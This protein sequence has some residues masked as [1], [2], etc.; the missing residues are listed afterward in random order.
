MD[1]TVKKLW[2]HALICIF[3][4]T[5]IFVSSTLYSRWFITEGKAVSSQ[6]LQP[7]VEVKA[8]ID[9]VV[10]YNKKGTYL[11][12]GWGFLSGENSPGLDN[13]ERELI[14]ISPV[15]TYRF[16]IEPAERP[17]V[18]EHFIS[19]GKN[20]EMAGFKSLISKYVVKPG[21]Y[22]VWLLVKKE[23]GAVICG[24]TGRVLKR[25]PNSLLLK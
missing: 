24:D 12:A 17:D 10:P 19:L 6:L 5:F 21:K 14:L 18:H 25:T 8:H 2:P 16:S 22:K 1:I 20:L 23:D 9:H 4:V 11:V 15:H 7:S 3:L 13:Y